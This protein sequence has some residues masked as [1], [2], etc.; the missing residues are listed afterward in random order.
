MKNL[1]EENHLVKIYG[2]HIIYYK[3]IDRYYKYGEIV[4]ITSS[5]LPPTSRVKVKC[6]CS[7]CSDIFEIP[8]FQYLRM[9]NITCSAK[10]KNA[11]TKKYLTKTYGV[12]N[13]SQLLSTKE[14]KKQKAIMKYGVENISQSIEIKQKKI[15]KSIENYGVE[16]I[17]QSEIIKNKKIETCRKN[18]GVDS[19]SQSP[20]LREK[21]IKT[22]QEKYGVNFTNISQIPEIMDKKLIT[23]ISARNHM[24]PSGKIVRVQ[25]YENFGIEYLLNIGINEDDIYIGN[26][27][28]ENEIGQ[29]W[30]FDE[31]NNKKRRYFPD[32]Y[33]K[34]QNKIIEVKSTYT[35]NLNPNLIELKKNAVIDKGLNF[36]FLIFDDK[37]NKNNVTQ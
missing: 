14:K 2:K 19:P 9:K 17:S 22:I 12:D 15:N 20:I 21:Y 33:I 28:I 3:K 30:F 23:G 26:K 13:I 36:E 8:Y 5:E 16:N 1:I 35:I 18:Y 34:S 10:C 31:L 11:A 25:G 7:E 6:I 24:L 37:G 29:I 4:N 27:N 32:I